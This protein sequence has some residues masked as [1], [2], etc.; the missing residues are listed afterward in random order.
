M[1]TQYTRKHIEEEFKVEGERIVSPGKYEGE[2]VYA[3]YFDAK[4]EA[5]GKGMHT[6]RDADRAEFPE[7][8]SY[9]T[10]VV[11]R[12]DSGHVSVQAFANA[13]YW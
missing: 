4:T 12:E 3:P 7:L 5:R 6:I 8:K 1:I 9:K 13:D 11:T 10:V 2:P